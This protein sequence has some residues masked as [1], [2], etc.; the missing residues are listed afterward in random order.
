MKATYTLEGD[1]AL[2][3]KCF[4]VL[5][6]LAAGIRTAYFPNFTAVSAN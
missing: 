4:D 5:G 2:V 3:F 1:G 6:S